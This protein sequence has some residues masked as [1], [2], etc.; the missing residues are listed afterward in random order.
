MRKSFAVLLL[1]AT[2]VFGRTA[3]AQNFPTRPITLIVPWPA[4][5]ATDVQMR[6]L[7]NAAEKHLG[8]RVI[9]ENRSGASGTLGP[10]E[11]AEMK[12][13]DGYTV[14]QIPVA[15]FRAPF[16][17]RTTFDPAK[18]LTYIIH[19]TGYTFG[20]VV[21]GDAPWKSFQELIADAKANPGKINYGTSG[22]GGTPHLTMEQIAT[23]QG[24]KWTHIPFNGVA[25]TV[26]AL[27]GGH[28]HV[29]ADGSGWAPQVSAG[30]FRLLVTWG[31]SRS[32]NWPNVPTLRD[33]GINIVATSPYGIAG[34]KGMD[35]KIVKILHDAFK[36]GLQEQPHL[37]TLARL[38]QEP[39]YLDS[40]DYHDFAMHEIAEQKRLLEEL[41]LR[42]Y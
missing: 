16:V 38:D 28:I 9:I 11:M 27:L 21:K 4:G 20:I 25:E 40:K 2:V 6:A 7:A 13:P 41:G 35:P 15:V 10:I 36:K 31:A 39:Y 26:K 23:H 1:F 19:L 37:A 42:Q 5:G 32:K 17:R 18:D 12:K 8:Q 33:I 14:A 22:T 29:G 34:P 3:E 24:V 30:Q